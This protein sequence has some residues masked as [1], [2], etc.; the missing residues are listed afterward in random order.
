MKLNKKITLFSVGLATVMIVVLIIVSLLSFR[1]F[2]IISAK[3]HIRSAAEIIRVSL[4]EDMVNGVIDKREGLLRRLG[5]VEGLRSVHVARGENVMRQFGKG[6]EQE[7]AAD[8]I[9]S[10]VLQDG[11]PYFV[12]LDEANGPVFRGTI[13]FVATRKGNPVCMQCHDVAEGA[14]LGAVTVTMSIGHLK[15]NAIFVSAIMVAAVAFFMVLMLVFFRRLIKPMVTT[16]NDVQEAVSHAI[17]GDFHANIQQRTRDEIGQVAVDVNKLMQFLHKGLSTIRADVS[18]LL[19]HKPSEEQGNLLNSTIAMVQGLIDASQFKQAIEEDESRT[20]IYQR[21]A[22]VVQERF[23]ISSFSIYEVQ[24]SKKQMIPIAVNGEFGASCHWCDPQILIRPETCRA[25]RTGHLIDSVETPGIC[26]A[27]RPPEDG[28]KYCHVC[29]PVIQSGQVGSVL[30]L[31]VK[32]EDSARMSEIIPYMNVYLREAAPVIEAKRLMDTLREANLRDAMTGLHNRRFLEEYVETLVAATQRR[33][34]Q[35]SI[36]MLD[37]DY[38]KMVNDT[39]GHDAGDTVLKTISKVMVQ[40]VRTSDMVIRYG[41]EEFL[42]ILLDTDG[43]GAVVVSEKIRTAVEEL[44]IQLT[45]AMLQKTISIGVAVFPTDS[46]TFWQTVKYAD[47]ALYKAKDSGRNRVIRF[48]PDLWT[49]E[50]TY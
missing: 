19:K 35:M 31:V 4:T 25:R 33:K 10:K 24:T 29:F 12:V 43:D 15:D 20:E 3:A 8:E 28:Q 45:G 21:L 32:Q 38:F 47:V 2:S 36:L 18:Q 7:S 50:R 34:S 1:Q 6:F 48:T 42:I 49:D 14:V 41:G 30:Q 40:S 5:E 26:K 16:A 46:D 9:E 39:Y 11:Q 22:T 17:N 13:P 44:K 23:G 37:L 27:F